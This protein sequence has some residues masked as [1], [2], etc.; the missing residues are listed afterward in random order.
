MYNKRGGFPAFVRNN[1]VENCKDQLLTGLRVRNILDEKTLRFYLKLSLYPD[2]LSTCGV[3]TD[4]PEELNSKES[5][6]IS[7]KSTGT[8]NIPYVEDTP[9]EI[10]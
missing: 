3:M 4:N 10:Q 6:F 8:L 2:A 7:S 1:F 5:F 9:M